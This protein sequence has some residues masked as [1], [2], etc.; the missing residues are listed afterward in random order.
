M[1]IMFPPL[2]LFAQIAVVH[3]SRKVKFGPSPNMRVFLGKAQVLAIFIVPDGR[4]ITLA[5]GKVGTFIKS[6]G[7]SEQLWIWPELTP[8][9]STTTPLEFDALYLLKMAWI[10]PHIST[11]L[12]ANCDASTSE[13]LA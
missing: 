9:A 2:K 11:P 8:R 7:L 12:P 13:K 3:A 4:S 1:S 5:D 6:H 10:A